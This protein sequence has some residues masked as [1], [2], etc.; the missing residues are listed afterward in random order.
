[1]NSFPSPASI[2]AYEITGM[3]EVLGDAWT[4]A[5]GAAQA[6]WYVEQWTRH[7]YSNITVRVWTGQ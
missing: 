2:V 5:A 3:S 4:L 7:G 6:V 1:M